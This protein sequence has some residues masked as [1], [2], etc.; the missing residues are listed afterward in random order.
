MF[1]KRLYISAF[2]VT[3]VGVWLEIWDR[4]MRKGMRQ[5]VVWFCGLMRLLVP[6]INVNKKDV[7]SIQWPSATLSAWIVVIVDRRELKE[8]FYQCVKPLPSVAAYFV[9][10]RWS[11][12]RSLISMTLGV[13]VCVCVWLCMFVHGHMLMC[14]HLLCVHIVWVC[15]GVNTCLC[16]HTNISSM[17][18]MPRMP[19]LLVTMLSLKNW[20]V[21]CQLVRLQTAVEHTRGELLL[22]IREREIKWRIKWFTHWCQWEGFFELLFGGYNWKQET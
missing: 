15:V 2:K 21:L 10:L 16:V 9:W 5:S 11:Q 4:G 14:V 8:L 1:R 22:G 3:W 18:G 6:T 20:L 13:C 7:N 17:A 12:D 19:L